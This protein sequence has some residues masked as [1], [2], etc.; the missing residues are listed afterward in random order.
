MIQNS[1]DC[2][3]AYAT[4]I[5]SEEYSKEPWFLTIG[6]GCEPDG[7]TPLLY[8]YTKRRVAR[9]T[10]RNYVC[11]IRV[12]VEFVGQPRALSLKS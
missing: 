1:V 8:V 7:K 6:V 12:A 9:K 3:I 4:Q 10:I 2:L 11:G 5:L